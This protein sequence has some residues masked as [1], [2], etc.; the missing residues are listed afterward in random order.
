MGDRARN[1][2]V[3]VSLWREQQAH[4]TRFAICLLLLFPDEYSRKTVHVKMSLI[5]REINTKTKPILIWIASHQDLFWNRGKHNSKWK[6]N[7]YY[8][9]KTGRIRGSRFQERTQLQKHRVESFVISFILL[10]NITKMAVNKV[11]YILVQSNEN[12]QV[13]D[14]KSSILHAIS[15]LTKARK[16]WQ[17]KSLRLDKDRE[18]TTDKFSTWKSIQWNNIC[19]VIEISITMY[20]KHGTKYAEMFYTKC[21]MRNLICPFE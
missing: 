10:A 11:L 4:N 3:V 12:V 18:D 16:Q 5:Y 1:F 17:K 9:V 7:V 15:F 13:S 20:H 14:K 6:K 19:H 8:G 2:K 21:Y